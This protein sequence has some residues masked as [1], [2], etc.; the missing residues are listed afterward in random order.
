M[1]SGR[2]SGRVESS[3]PHA[4]PTPEVP[5]S[6]A[7]ESR[8][9]K[10]VATARVTDASVQRLASKLTDSDRRII[11]SLA[12][13]RI[14]TG[15]QLQALHWSDSDSDKRL[16]RHHLAKLTSLRLVARLDRRVGGIRAGSDGF[17]YA[18][19]VA[20]LRLVEDLSPARRRR[21]STPGDR[22]LAHALAV[23]DCYV[24]LRRIQATGDLELLGFEAEPACWRTYPG[25]G[26][27]LLTIKPDAFA[28]LADQ[29][30]EHRWFIEVDRDTEHRPTI[31]RKAKEYVDY[32]RSGV[33]QRQHDLFPKVLW[34]APTVRRADELQG[35]LEG[36]DQR[37]AEL[38]EVCTTADFA[39]T[40]GHAAR[41]SEV[42]S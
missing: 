6:S 3:T 33:E 31:L 8:R 9:R 22:Y 11:D 4:R 34:V 20:G 16:A 10:S 42:S 37:S 13:V 30:W 32:W 1:I 5:T 24:D 29:E 12:T 26:G 18:L 28:L 17:T 23:T 2:L 35:V 41:S 7:K 21:P 39:G 19:D 36:V 27:Q 25:H 15:R 14:A 38:F 40:I